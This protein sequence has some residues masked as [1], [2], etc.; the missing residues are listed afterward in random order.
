MLAN[1]TCPSAQLRPE[2]G[3]SPK[4]APAAL[5][6]AGAAFSPAPDPVK[7]AYPDGAEA[8]PA[9]LARRSSTPLPEK[10]TR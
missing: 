6:A 9:I 4:L 2:G 7:P 1:E 5:E 10:A 3:S 8:S